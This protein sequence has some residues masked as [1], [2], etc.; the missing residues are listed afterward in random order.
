ME[1]LGTTFSIM[2]IVGLIGL[3]IVAV[4]SIKQRKKR[5]DTLN[6]EVLTS[7]PGVV[8]KSQDFPELNV[9]AI[10][11]YL[12]PLRNDEPVFIHNVANLLQRARKKSDIKVIRAVTEQLEAQGTL[13]TKIDEYE[14]QFHRLLRKKEN[15]KQRDEIQDLTHER[16]KKRILN[17]IAVLAD[18]AG[19]KEKARQKEYDELQTQLTHE[20]AV[21]AL[22]D[23]LAET[24]DTEKRFS[25]NKQLDDMVAMFAKQK[26]AIEGNSKLPPRARKEA[27]RTLEQTFIAQLDEFKKGL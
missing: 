1:Y 13:L 20:Y 18:E 6:A 22:K 16:D 19:G 7:G 23:R 26:E 17:E 2:V 10:R 8:R 12:T 25:K 3:T 21:Q 5:L 11:N 15:L 27:V 14:E 9:D 24:A 4:I